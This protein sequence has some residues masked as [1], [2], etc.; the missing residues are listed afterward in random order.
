MNKVFKS[1]FYLVGTIFTNLFLTYPIV[2]FLMIGMFFSVAGVSFFNLYEN[3][4]NMTFGSIDVLFS[5]FY[6]WFVNIFFSTL[7]LLAIMI[8]VLTI[9]FYDKLYHFFKKYPLTQ[10]Q[11]FLL[12]ALLVTCFIY[13]FTIPSLLFLVV[14][15]SADILIFVTVLLLVGVLY[16][17]FVSA[18]VSIMQI[19][20]QIFQTLFKSIFHKNLMWIN[21]FIAISPFLMLLMY[22]DIWYAI[23]DFPVWLFFG[24]HFLIITLWY[25]KW[26]VNIFLPIKKPRLVINIE[27]MKHCPIA[28]VNF[29]L[30]MVRHLNDFIIVIVSIFILLLLSSNDVALISSRDTFFVMI[31]LLLIGLGILNH[32]IQWYSRIAKKLYDKTVGIYLFVVFIIVIVISLCISL[33]L[34]F[35]ATLI[36]S[37]LL[38]LKIKLSFHSEK[39][40][41]V[42]FV[43]LLSVVGI[44]L[45]GIFSAI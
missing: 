42:H 33:D 12:T 21:I 15:L 35:Y 38:V 18:Y 36:I 29:I 22:T 8:F 4:S 2:L 40:S 45:W 17:V 1:A 26:Q 30:V 7:V 25:F 28:I 19:I 39:M 31:P 11:I 27:K 16:F 24:L 37:V 43:T 32:Y 34:H 6:M 41:S 3:F 9:Y 44:V 20:Y 10:K 23:S 5:Q 14:I 13:I